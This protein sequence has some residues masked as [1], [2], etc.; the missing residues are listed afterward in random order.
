MKTCF[1]EE[2]GERKREERREGGRRRQTKEINRPGLEMI[3]HV[4]QG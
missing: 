4:S 3:C 2:R 1:L